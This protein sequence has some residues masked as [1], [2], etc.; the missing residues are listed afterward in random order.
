MRQICLLWMA[1]GLIQGVAFAEE[2]GLPRVLIIGDSI[3]I[4]Y[5]EPLREIL[6]AEAVVEHNT[7]NARHS[8]YG[9]ENLDKWLGDT[10]WDVI[11]FNFG[12]HDLKYVDTKGE[13]APS[14][15]EGTI[16]IGVEEYEKNLE[17]IVKRLQQ[18]GARLIF[19]TTTAYPDRP[20]GPLRNLQD[21]GIYNAA[22]L[23]VMTAHTVP[24]NDLYAFTK[25]RLAEL[26]QPNNVHFT[27]AGSR[28][29]AEEVAQT[30]RAALKSNP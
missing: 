11:H 6:A 14:A 19:A 20:T 15:A 17:G 1:A 25:D 4:G 28:V 27:K 21:L 10:K 22:A 2:R 13:N 26:Q 8:R 24:V 5:T 7:G 3:S 30:I 9:L 23:R 29:L 12:L 18:T 16:Q